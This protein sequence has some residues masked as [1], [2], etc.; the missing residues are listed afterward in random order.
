MAVKSEHVQS[1]TDHESSPDRKSIETP[2]LFD[3]PSFD[4]ASDAFLKAIPPGID[5][6]AAALR[7]LQ[8]DMRAQVMTQFQQ[9][10]GNYY[11]QRVMDQVH[12]TEQPADDLAQR[13]QAASADG[14][15]LDAATRERLQA[16]LGV[17][18]SGVRVH[19]DDEADRLAESVEAIAFTTGND[20]FF[21]AGRYQP[22]TAW[23]LRLLAHEVTHTLQ[24]SNG[25]VDGTLNADGVSISDPSD[26]FEQAAEQ[27]A[28]QVL[29]GESAAPGY[30]N[31]ATNTSG[32]TTVQRDEYSG[33]EDWEGVGWGVGGDAEQVY[34]T[35]P[36]KPGEAP[37]EFNPYAYAKENEQGGYE[38]GGALLQGADEYLD[39]SFGYGEG[40]AGAWGDEGGTRYGLKA[41]AGLAKADINEGGP[42]SGNVGSVTG[43]VEA[44]V[45]DSGLTVGIGANAG[46]GAI[47]IG[48]MS[49]Q[50]K[51][52]ES[53][54][55]GA[56]A[57]LGFGGRLHWG[58]SDKDKQREYG[59]G[60]DVGPVSFDYK[61]EDPLRSA[62][63][64]ALTKPL[65]PD[66]KV[67]MTDTAI[68]YGSAA[69]SAIAEYGGAAYDTVAGTAG[70]AWDT[71]SD[72]AGSAYDTAAGGVNDAWNWATDW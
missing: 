35:E 72:F 41:G 64:G 4:P 17:D 24:Q 71:T 42:V 12:S 46:E 26:G 39:V 40:K 31:T 61:T 49:D 22:E 60:F 29:A 18:L 28:D 3:E 36:A 62:L 66:S 38:A 10:F 59:L 2:R 8:G 23:G 14:N 55:L 51:T 54:T 15:G 52:D 19:L 53:V 16:G 32:Q 27:A 34:G 65:L 44:S 50:S 67:N 9:D 37:G 47:D 25:P 57:G 43:N 30:Q 68:D 1:T 63:G 33:D 58:D 69:G 5:T 20:I 45:G 48:N 13:I 11:V 56:S 21:R 70:K 7:R 6:H